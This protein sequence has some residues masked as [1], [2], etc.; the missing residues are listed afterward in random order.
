MHDIPSHMITTFFQLDHVSAVKTA[1]PPFFFSLLQNLVRLLVRGTR[2]GAVP[3][4]VTVTAHTSLAAA[5][6]A[7]L[8]SVVVT[9]DLVGSDPSAA[10][11]ARAVD[12]VPGGEFVELLVPGLLEV[13][14]E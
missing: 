3:S 14:V 6:F 10:S 12:A 8:A 11:L 4:V 9:L 7:H 5:A 2:V 1:L 13:D